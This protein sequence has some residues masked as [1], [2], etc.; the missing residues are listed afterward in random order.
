MKFA[1]L[2]CGKKEFS[3]EIKD[4]NSEG[5][6]VSFICPNCESENAV[7]LVHQNSVK[8]KIVH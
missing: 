3:V 6:F 8:I 4:L 7:S 2:E 1:C 5:I